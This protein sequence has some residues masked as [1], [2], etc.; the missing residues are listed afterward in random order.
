MCTCSSVWPSW[1]EETAA[2]AAVAVLARSAS[3]TGRVHCFVRGPPLTAPDWWSRSEAEQ[4]A[5]GKSLAQHVVIGPG[6]TA[7]AAVA[8]RAAV[9]GSAITARSAPSRA[10]RGR[11]DLFVLRLTRDA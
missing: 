9:A 5:A 2:D 10:A 3:G 6:A 11:N 1:R 7:T 8:D 4:R